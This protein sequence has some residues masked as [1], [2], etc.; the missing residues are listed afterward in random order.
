LSSFE[1]KIVSILLLS[2]L[3]ISYHLIPLQLVS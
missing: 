3:V 1:D 2:G